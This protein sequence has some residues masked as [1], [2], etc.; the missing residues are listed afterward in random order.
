MNTTIVNFN[1]K[2]VQPYLLCS[3]FLVLRT[4]IRPRKQNDRGNTF[5]LLFIFCIYALIVTLLCP[6]I[7]EGIKVLD[8]AIDSSIAEGGQSLKFGMSNITQIGYLLLNCSTLYCVWRQRNTI[9]LKDLQN[10]FILTTLMAVVF[11]LWEFSSKIV[12]V[13]FPSDFIFNGAQESGW[14]YT[15]SV[16][17]Y[18]RLS[19]VFG[20]SSF[21][22]AF[23]AS[24]FW[25]LM[26][27]A[28][29]KWNWK[30]IALL[31]GVFLCL[32]LGLSGIGVVAFCFGGLIY[33]IFIKRLR[34]KF[35]TVR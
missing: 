9:D 14:L 35:I 7:F 6:Q 18:M 23:M 13:Y 27:I 29:D 30:Y 8:K 28:D 2:I 17:G 20:E 15:S 33:A 21:C 3:M 31:A 16:Y 34:F 11:G 22:G 1:G 25:G 24:A 26:V 5:R 32:V 10:A 4:I 19:S 12:G